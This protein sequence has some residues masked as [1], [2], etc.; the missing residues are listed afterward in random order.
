MAKVEKINLSDIP[1]WIYIIATM[2]YSIYTNKHGLLKE[3]IRKGADVN[4]MCTNQSSWIQEAFLVALEHAFKIKPRT[5]KSVFNSLP[6][7]K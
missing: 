5:V 6:I 2:Y 3:C 4:F 1:E 7:M